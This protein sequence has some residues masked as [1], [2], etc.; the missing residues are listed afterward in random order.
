MTA[1][2]PPQDSLAGQAKTMM[3]IHVAPEGSSYNESTSTLTFGTRVS[4]VQLGQARKN[5]E[6]AELF[7][8]REQLARLQDRVGDAAAA[9]AECERLR[10]EVRM[11][12]AAMA[13]Q[14]QHGGGSEAEDLRREVLLIRQQAQHYKD[15]VLQLQTQL[16][17][18]RAAAAAAGS[19]RTFPVSAGNSPAR[20]AT[21][22]GSAGGRPQS[23]TPRNLPWR[24]TESSDIRSPDS[25]AE[26]SPEVRSAGAAC[27]TVSSY[28][29]RVSAPRFS[30]SQVRPR[31][32]SPRGQ[33]RIEEP[34]GAAELPLRPKGSLVP[35]LQLAAASADQML[36]QALPP[37]VRAATP[38]RPT[39][40]RDS[41]A[42]AARSESHQGLARTGL[43]SPR[44]AWEAPLSARVPSS[45]NVAPS[46]A[47]SSITQGLGLV[48]EPSD[49]AVGGGKR[50]SSF[51]KHVSRLR[52]SR[53]APAKE[54]HH[55][56]E[57][58]S[59]SRL[60]MAAAGGRGSGIPSLKTPRTLPQAASTPRGLGGAGSPG[61]VE[62][63]GGFGWSPKKGRPSSGVTPGYRANL[64]SR[65]SSAS[66]SRKGWM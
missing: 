58:P 6:S 11:L 55:L 39:S 49:L 62:T 1:A 3:F 41:R 34:V 53:D 23:Q 9:E 25:D 21:S 14:Q 52:R 61:P 33:S 60:S 44:P 4:A 17:Q 63:P 27:S 54:N 50:A 16:S 2:S 45:Y 56:G 38:P 42:R 47:S 24:D 29:T 46:P 30:Q 32:G 19:L 8:A 31:Y 13:E 28:L 26:G 18:A 35:K 66:S 64:G 43:T 37:P 51:E 22:Q 5:T 57:E 48:R 36:L 65:P 10:S 7:A 15:Q 40:A 12:R 20:P 59:S